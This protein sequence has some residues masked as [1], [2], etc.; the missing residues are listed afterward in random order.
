MPHCGSLL[1][2][3]VCSIKSTFE[4]LYHNL[5]MI[6]YIYIY[7]WFWVGLAKKHKFK[8]CP[9]L[10]D[11]HLLTPRVPANWGADQPP[12]PANF[13]I[14]VFWLKQLKIMHIYTKSSKNY[15]IGLQR[16]FLGYIHGVLRMIHS[17]AF[18]GG[19]RTFSFKIKNK[20]IL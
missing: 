7:A 1:T 5:S 13:W 2:H 4:A 17:E 16:Y 11:D 14:Y 18:V 15:D 6:S 10:G 19:K 12:V 20:V 9:A 8:N 3:H